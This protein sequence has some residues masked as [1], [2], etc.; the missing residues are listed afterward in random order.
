MRA[1]RDVLPEFS[2]ELE[3]ILAAAKRSD[4]ASQVDALPLVD[5][6]RCGQSEC[7]H[8]YTAARTAGAYGPGHENLVLDTSGLVVLDLVDGRIVAV[9]VL[10]R[11]D[12]KRFST[13]HCRWKGRKAPGAHHDDPLPP[14]W[15]H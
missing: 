6:C 1:I 5:R 12:V 8:F 13:S 10:D 9:E 15:A 7:A 2:A 11:Q 3:R 14:H 4:L